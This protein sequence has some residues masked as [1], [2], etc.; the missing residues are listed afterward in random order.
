LLGGLGVTPDY[1]KASYYYKL[2]SDSGIVD[3]GSMIFN[4][5]LIYKYSIV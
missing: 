1:E 5:I 4:I 2:A 3:A